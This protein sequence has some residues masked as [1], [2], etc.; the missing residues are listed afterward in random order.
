ML[1]Y[2]LRIK[3]QYYC[4][5]T[6]FPRSL[7]FG[8]V[9][10]FVFGNISYGNAQGFKMQMYTNGYALSEKFLEKQ[11]GIFDLEM[12]RISLYGHDAESYYK[13]TKNKKGYDIVLKNIKNFCKLVEQ[14]NSKIKFPNHLPPMSAGLIGYL[15]YETVELYENM[16][17]RKS[18]NLFLPDGFFMR[19]TIMAIFD[20]INNEV[21]LATPL[22]ADESANIKK[23]YELK[24]NVLDKTIHDL[25]SFLKNKN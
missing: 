8:C 2:R 17:E 24:L 14:N 23:K 10:N 25:N 18:S 7:F 4:G 22:W 3:Y 13:V 16:P 20:N 6:Q 5:N 19:P 21:T 12:M 11:P 9:S 1:H 15:S